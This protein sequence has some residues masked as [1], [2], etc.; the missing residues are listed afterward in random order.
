MPNCLDDVSWGSKVPRNGTT[1]K[2]QFKI[3]NP[4]SGGFFEGKFKDDNGPTE[5]IY[6]HCSAASIWFLRP[7]SSPIYRYSG[8]FIY[9]GSEKRY[10]DGTRTLVRADSEAIERKQAVLPLPPGDDWEGDKGT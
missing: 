10:I 8:N 1:E 3:T 4:L 2:G 6:G 9:V 7:A 5:D